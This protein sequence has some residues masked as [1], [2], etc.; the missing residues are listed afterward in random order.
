M[1]SFDGALQLQACLN[2][3]LQQFHINTVGAYRAHDLQHCFVRVWL[4]QTQTCESLL[5]TTLDVLFSGGDKVDVWGKYHCRRDGRRRRVELR[6]RA[7]AQ[8]SFAVRKVAGRAEIARALREELA[9]QRLLLVIA[10]H[11]PRQHLFWRRC[12]HGGIFSRRTQLR[13]VLG[14]KRPKA[15]IVQP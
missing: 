13:V 11:R 14:R 8:V 2:L 5:E 3:R 10:P 12:S 15:T 7:R 6:C 4:G 9:E 1:K